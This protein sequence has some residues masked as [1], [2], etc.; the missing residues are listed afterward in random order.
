MTRQ[1]IDKR[2]EE[3][4]K[5]YIGK[6]VCETPELGYQCVAWVK[7]FAKEALGEVL[8]SFSGSAING[9]NSGSPFTSSW[10]R[11]VNTPNPNLVPKK[12]DIIFFKP[13]PKNKYGHVAVVYNSYAGLD[14]VDIVEQNGGVGMGNGVGSDA[15]R[16]NTVPYTN[17]VGWYSWKQKKDLLQ[18]AKD[19]GIW[20]WSRATEPATRSET[21][22][23]I[24]RLKELV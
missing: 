21:V 19:I 10:E 16:F 11:V 12:G 18:E 8:G 7:Q 6:K 20:D 14:K 17:V 24:M 15:I 13:T 5:S 22:L 3:V 2:T 9:W 23:M 4:C 1:E